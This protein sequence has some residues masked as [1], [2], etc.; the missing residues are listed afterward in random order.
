MGTGGSTRHVQT[1]PTSTEFRTEQIAWETL[2]VSKILFFF[3]IL[4]I[5]FHFHLLHVAFVPFT[6]R[7]VFPKTLFIITLNMNIR[8]S[9]ELS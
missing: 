5:I 2:E 3:S 4:K 8:H 6:A 1:A 7:A 9:T